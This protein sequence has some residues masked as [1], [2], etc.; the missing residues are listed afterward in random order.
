[1]KYIKHK[2]LMRKMI[3]IAGSCMLIALYTT[4]CEWNYNQQRQAMGE[5]FPPNGEMRDVQRIERVQNASGAREDATL[6]PYHFDKGEVNSLGREKLSLM[7]DD[8]DTNNPI[9]IYLNLPQDDEFKAPRQDS[10]IAYL[11]DQ[12]LEEKQVSFKPGNNP[13]N[14]HPAAEGLA[15]YENT[16]TGT[17]TGGQGAAG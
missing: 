4:G 1:M 10:I 17:A 12:G 5:F 3:L 15:N 16:A 11:K 13:G 7:L 9:T 14:Y 8:D 2:K 6:Q